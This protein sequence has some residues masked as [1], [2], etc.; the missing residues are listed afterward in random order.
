M[1]LL[2]QHAILAGKILRRHWQRQLHQMERC[3]D[4]GARPGPGR[5]VLVLPA[6]ATLAVYVA[7][8][9]CWHRQ[10]SGMLADAVRTLATRPSDWIHLEAL[11]GSSG[12]V[13][14]WLLAS[15]TASALPAAVDLTFPAALTEAVHAVSG[16]VVLHSVLHM[17]REDLDAYSAGRAMMS[18]SRPSQAT[19][20][21]HYTG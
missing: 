14:P 5:V 2:R 10:R 13:M 15:A 18:P 9:F 11:G 17:P 1:P 12:R 4:L 3:L 7:S 8:A 21:T 19:I 16:L 20:R 6:S